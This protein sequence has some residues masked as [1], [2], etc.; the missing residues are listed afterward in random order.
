MSWIK[1]QNFFSK[2]YILF[3]ALLTRIVRI[4]KLEDKRQEAV[5]QGHSSKVKSVAITSDRKYIVS[6]GDDS[7][8]R[9]WNL[10]DKRQ[11]AVLQGHT[12]WVSSIAVATYGTYIIFSGYDK[13]V[14]IWS[15]K[16]KREK[17]SCKAILE[18]SQV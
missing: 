1:S 17:L 6:D 13:A 10:R 4:W 15:L 3:P 18:K 5:L 9:V 16:D 14:R 7:T 12:N 11:E 8:V 2:T